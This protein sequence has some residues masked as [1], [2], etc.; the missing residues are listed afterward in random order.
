MAHTFLG[1][2]ENLLSCLVLLESNKAEWEERSQA[3]QDRRHC[4]SQAE[5]FSLNLHVIEAAWKLFKLGGHDHICSPE[6]SV[7]QLQGRGI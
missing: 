5:A 6:G 4:P 1:A 7:N 3:A 2:Y